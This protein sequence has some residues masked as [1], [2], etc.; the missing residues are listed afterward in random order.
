MRLL[1]VVLTAFS[2]ALVASDAQ[3]DMLAGSYTGFVFATPPRQFFDLGN[4]LA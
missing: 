1:H 4:F 3:A 2:F